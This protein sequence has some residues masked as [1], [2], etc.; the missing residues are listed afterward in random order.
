MN[1]QMSDNGVIKL[2]YGTKA[3]EKSL[4]C[5]FPIVSLKK[6]KKVAVNKAN[7]DGMTPLEQASY[8]G[9]KEIVNALIAA[10]ANVNKSD[11]GNTPLYIASCN[12]HKEIVSMYWL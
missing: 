5:S 12:G 2:W 11:Y 10:G 1:D 7:N 8:N 9:H 6:K 3:I 4:D